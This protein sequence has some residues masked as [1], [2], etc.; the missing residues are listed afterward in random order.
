[1][2]CPEGREPP[3]VIYPDSRVGVMQWLAVCGVARGS[4]TLC[5]DLSVAS[6]TVWV[7][8]EAVRAASTVDG[9]ARLP[10]PDAAI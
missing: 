8:H 4:D 6:Y 2:A 5:F 9:D 10:N 1:M 7:R 3:R